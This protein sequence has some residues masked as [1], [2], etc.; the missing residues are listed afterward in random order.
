MR[1]NGNTHFTATPFI[2]TKHGFPKENIPLM[3]GM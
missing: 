3:S 1:V 2:K